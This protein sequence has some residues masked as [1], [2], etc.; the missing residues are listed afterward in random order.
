[1][2]RPSL[3]EVFADVRDQLVSVPVPFK[4][5]SSEFNFKDKYTSQELKAF[6][7]SRIVQDKKWP[8]PFGHTMLIA[9]SKSDFY[10]EINAVGLPF[11]QQL[12]A[13]MVATI[14]ACPTITQ[15]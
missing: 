14:L 10:A 6:V 4:D 5:D 8:I 3:F 1:V 9:N 13:D 11:V 7:A 12:A 15:S 2:C